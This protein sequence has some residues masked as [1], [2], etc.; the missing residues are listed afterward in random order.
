MLAGLSASAA[1]AAEVK[2]K[3]W[4]QAGSIIQ[5]RYCNYLPYVS[6]SSSLNSQDP[7]DTPSD[8]S[9]TTPS[10]PQEGRSTPNPYT[11][12]RPTFPGTPGPASAVPTTAAS[13]SSA[14][15]E[16]EKVF[17]LSTAGGMGVGEGGGHGPVVGVSTDA[18]VA[19]T[20]TTDA[21]VAVETPAAVEPSS[22]TSSAAEALSTSSTPSTSAPS[23]D[24]EALTDPLISAINQLTASLALA[25]ERERA[26]EREKRGLSREEARAQMQPSRRSVDLPGGEGTRRMKRERRI[27][28]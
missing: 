1:G 8:P 7:T 22:S 21:S 9:A 4:I 12:Q 16:A 26:R 18:V 28:E 10:I 2:S 20:T 5:V 25:R 24:L 11:L 6:C 14:S 23:L 27:K 15:S 19:S 17:T 13:S 3:R